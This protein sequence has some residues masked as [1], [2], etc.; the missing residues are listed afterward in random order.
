MGFLLIAV[1]PINKIPL[2]SP[3]KVHGEVLQDVMP[4]PAAGRVEHLMDVF[5]SQNQNMALFVL[6]AG[7]GHMRPILQ[8]FLSVIQD[9]QNFCM[10]QTTNR[11]QIL[12]FHQ[13]D[14]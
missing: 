1:D 5:V 7:L 13:I 12:N 4:K 14:A 2:K 8:A 6:D 3:T 9:I 10:G 11:L